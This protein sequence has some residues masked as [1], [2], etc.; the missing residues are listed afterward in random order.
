MDIAAGDIIEEIPAHTN[1]L[2]T[3]CLLPD[4]VRFRNFN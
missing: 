4:L 3:I 1:E 2:W